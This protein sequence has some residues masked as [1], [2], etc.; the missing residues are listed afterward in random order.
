MATAHVFLCLVAVVLAAAAAAS[1]AHHQHSQ[2]LDNPPDLSLR[3]GGESGEVVGDLPGGFRAYVT[4]R[5]KSSRA[6]VLAS[7]VF[8]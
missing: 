6:V 7:D 2:C 4:G 1:P 8:G 3:A 5:A